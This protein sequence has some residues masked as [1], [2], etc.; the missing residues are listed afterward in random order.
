MRFHFPSFVLGFGAGAA[1]ATLGRRLR[2]LALELATAVYQVFDGVAARTA[3][4]REDVDDLVAEARAQARE[5]TRPSPRA[6]TRTRK[7]AQSRAAR[8]TGAGASV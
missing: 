3:M 6:R 5:R 8:A 1:S 7:Q 4:F 2:P